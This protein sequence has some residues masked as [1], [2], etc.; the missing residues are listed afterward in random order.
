MAGEQWNSWLQ[1]CRE[2][3]SLVLVIVAIAL[4]LDNMLLTT[5]GKSLLFLAYPTF[6]YSHSPRAH[7]NNTTPKIE[8]LSRDSSISGLATCYNLCRLDCQRG[9][10]VLAALVRLFIRAINCSAQNTASNLYVLLL[11][12]LTFHSVIALSLHLE[13]L[14]DAIFSPVCKLGRF[15][16]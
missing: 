1:R 10:P 4:L 7:L 6:L 9:Q 2:S 12:R 8:W 13:Q 5:V 11:L 16:E 15:R 3:R 14:V